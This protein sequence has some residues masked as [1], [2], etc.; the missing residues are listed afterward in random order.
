MSRGTVRQSFSTF[1]HLSTT[2]ERLRKTTF[3]KKLATVSV[4]LLVSE[5]Y[6]AS[7]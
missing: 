2:R 5:C 4:I 1:T 6:T 3:T 7:E